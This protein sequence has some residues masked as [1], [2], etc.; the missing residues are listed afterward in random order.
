M[1]TMD[2][3]LIDEKSDD[4]KFIIFCLGEELYGAKLLEVREVVEAIQTKSVPNTISSFMGVCNLRGQI[5][6]VVD[7]RLRF[8]IEAPVAERPIFLVFD[9]D[10]GGIAAA[11][12]RIVSVSV[13][14][15]QDV[16]VRPNIV[17]NIPTRYILGIGKLEQRLI[18]LV[19]LRQ[20]LSQEELARVEQS[21]MLLKVGT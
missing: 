11:V 20:V 9:T 15:S 12:D 4:N 14:P 17:S 19:D 5:I 2:Q 21:R 13:I 1:N 7:L 10:S 6:G 18:T 8:S 16:E 3:N